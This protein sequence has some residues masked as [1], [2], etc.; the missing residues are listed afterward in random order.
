[1][2][3][4]EH[5]LAHHVLPAE[6]VPEYVRKTLEEGLKREYIYMNNPKNKIVIQGDKPKILLCEQAQSVGV[7]S[8]EEGILLAKQYARKIIEINNQ[9]KGN[10][11][12]S[13]Y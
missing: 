12:T 3:S 4:H 6:H 11:T 5:I 9:T 10:N 13:C 7:V 8:I 2:V 1:M